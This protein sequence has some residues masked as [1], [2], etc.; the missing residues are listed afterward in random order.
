MTNQLITHQLLIDYRYVWRETR[1]QLVPGGGG[2][3]RG[4]GNEVGEKFPSSPSWKDLYGFMS[5]TFDIGPSG[6]TPKITATDGKKWF[7]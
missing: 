1:D 6:I 5:S 2:K 4:P 7:L 3:M